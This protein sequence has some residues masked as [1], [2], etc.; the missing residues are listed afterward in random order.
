M[1]YA[2]PQC[3]K[4]PATQNLVV[5]VSQFV[6]G[7]YVLYRTNDCLSTVDPLVGYSAETLEDTGVDIRTQ[8]S[9]L[10][11]GPCQVNSETVGSGC[12]S[13][14]NPNPNGKTVGNL[15]QD[16]QL[17]T[18]RRTHLPASTVPN[19]DHDDYLPSTT[20]FS[21]PFKSSIFL[22]GADHSEQDSLNI[23]DSE[24]DQDEYIAAV[25]EINSGNSGDDTASRISLSGTLD[26]QQASPTLSSS[27]LVNSPSGFPAFSSAL[28]IH[29]QPGSQ[30]I[31]HHVPVLRPKK[32]VAFLRNPVMPPW[33]PGNGNFGG[34]TALLSGRKK[35]LM[36]LN[37][38]V[39]HCELEDAERAALHPG[40]DHPRQRL[41]RLSLHG[42]PVS[43]RHHKR[44]AR[45]R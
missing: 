32:R 30:G 45:Y 33:D 14:A 40:E 12:I 9:F 29:E 19:T 36:D 27:S 4:R 5:L 38:T 44:D 22:L 1:Q 41:P 13:I 25:I 18:N 10:I 8:S 15:N 2:F 35:G 17:P 3:G 37:E 7:T 6:T 42:K 11:N 21:Q 26:S 28:H 20:L 39:L 23:N 43:L 34:G 31:P 16:Y 24:I